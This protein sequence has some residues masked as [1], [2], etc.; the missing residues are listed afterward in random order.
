[1]LVQV[2]AAG[3]ALIHVPAVSQLNGSRA[4]PRQVYA[5]SLAYVCRV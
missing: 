2:S 3:Y 4:D 5:N 1:M